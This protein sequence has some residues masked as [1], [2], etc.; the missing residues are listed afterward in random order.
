MSHRLDQEPEELSEVQEQQVKVN[1]GGGG[2]CRDYHN[3]TRMMMYRE[4]IP[5]L[6]ADRFSLNQIPHRVMTPTQQ[7]LLTAADQ[8]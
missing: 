8:K 5:L 7:A 1:K 3:T 2:S 4:Q 6:I